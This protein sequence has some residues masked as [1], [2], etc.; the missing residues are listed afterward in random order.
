[1]SIGTKISA[2]KFDEVHVS[3]IINKRYRC[4]LKVKF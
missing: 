2:T 1:V 4:R 3:N